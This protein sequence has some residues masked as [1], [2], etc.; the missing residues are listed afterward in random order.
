MLAPIFFP[1]H[2]VPKCHLHGELLQSSFSPL[3]T[4]IS[5][6]REKANTGTARLWRSVLKYSSAMVQHSTYRSAV[7]RCRLVVVS[8]QVLGFSFTANPI[9]VLRITCLLIIGK[10]ENNLWKFCYRFVG[11][12]MWVLFQ[13]GQFALEAL[14]FDQQQVSICWRVQYH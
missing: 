12:D 14:Q 3:H 7:I 4:V 2:L 8:S 1:L 5:V 11:S 13:Y 9:P 10:F 6:G